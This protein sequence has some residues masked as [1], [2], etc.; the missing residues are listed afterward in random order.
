[1]DKFNINNFDRFSLASL[2]IDKSEST[3]ITF[4]CGTLIDN[5]LVVLPEPQPVSRTISFPF[6]FLY[7]IISCPYDSCVSEI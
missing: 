6:H 2:I 5:I 1:L 7:S 3:A 4:P